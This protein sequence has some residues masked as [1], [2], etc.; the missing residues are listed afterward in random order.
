MI[1][2]TFDEKTQSPVD[3]ARALT[4]GG[5]ANIDKAIEAWRKVVQAAPDKR[6]PRRQLAQL[7]RRASRWN[8]LV[9]VLKEE[10]EKLG[11]AEDVRADRLSVLH[12]MV[13]V[14]RDQL[15]LDA[16]VIST[17]NQILALDPGNEAAVD[18]LCAQ[19]ERM[20][21]WPDLIGLLQKRALAAGTPADQRIALGLRVAGLFIERFSNQSEAIK[22]YE[23]VLELEP[24][25][26]AALGALKGM[27]EKRRDWEKLIA[28]L[29]REAERLP[30]TD[31]AGRLARATTR[32][33]FSRRSTRASAR[34][35]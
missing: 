33:R 6:G 8:A 7:Y 16:M 35:G 3:Q 27:Y 18:A 13:E 25:N 31:P 30:A 32:A 19:Y 4:E 22:A 29:K 24:S 15:H 17:Y 9:E 20:K 23:G 11:T 10:H 26:E 34:R 28:V 21:R 5:E 2:E 14:Y 12:E 1:T